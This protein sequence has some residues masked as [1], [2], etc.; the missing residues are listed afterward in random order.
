[1]PDRAI[2]RRC[3][4]AAG[5]AR[6]VVPAHHRRGEDVVRVRAGDVD[7]IAGH[8]V[9]RA[10]AASR[11]VGRVRQIDRHRAATA[12]DRDAVVGAVDA[13]HAAG[14]VA[15]LARRVAAALPR[16][17]LHALQHVDRARADLAAAL[18]R[19]ALR[20]DADAVALLEVGNAVRVAL[21][22]HR[23]RRRARRRGPRTGGRGRCPQCAGGAPAPQPASSPKPSAW[24]CCRDR[25]SGRFP[26]AAPRPGARAA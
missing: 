22:A 10:H 12:V 6:V 2:G 24:R 26:S 18:D 5:A 7:L 15:D 8:H 9:G 25:A 19:A 13:R 16:A 17:L 20:I 4:A 1:M 3:R 23:C 14:Q 11:R 21:V